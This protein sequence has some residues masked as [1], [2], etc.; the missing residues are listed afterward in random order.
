MKSSPRFT[1]NLTLLVLVLLFAAAP[2]VLAQDPANTSF[3]S[4]VEKAWKERIQR[5]SAYSSGSATRAMQWK[6]LMPDSQEEP[7]YT[8]ASFEWKYK[9]PL[10]LSEG[11]VQGGDFPAAHI[12][13]GCNQLSWKKGP[14]RTN[15]QYKTWSPS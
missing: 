14:S 3:K 11:A 5:L 15:G 13:G 7:A 4:D 12:V 6:A 9:F 8:V 1:T 10:L 2:A